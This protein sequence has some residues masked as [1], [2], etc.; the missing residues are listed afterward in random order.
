MTFYLGDR[1]AQF[2]EEMS[3][4]LKFDMWGECTNRAGESALVENSHEHPAIHD[5]VFVELKH[6]YEAYIHV[7]V[8]DL[9]LLLLDAQQRGAK[10]AAFEGATNRE[11]VEE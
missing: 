2:C 6:L 1:R 11:S 10:L 9:V 7:E 8:G 5:D 3:E 4:V